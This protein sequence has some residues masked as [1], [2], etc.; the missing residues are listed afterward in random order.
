MSRWIE[1]LLYL[2][3][4]CLIVPMVSSAQPVIRLYD[5]LTELYPDSVFK[6][7][8]KEY[9]ID[10]AR[11]T[12]A[13]VHILMM[14][15]DPGTVARFRVVQG[16]KTVAEARWYRMID[17]P[18]E[19]NT[20]LD[21]RTEKFSGQINP[22][23]IRRAPFRIFEAL[24]PVRSPMAIDK[25]TIALRVEIPTSKEAA[26]KKRT[27]EIVIDID[28]HIEK[29][30]WIINVHNAVIPSLRHSTI[31][32]VNWHN[33]DNICGDH[34][35]KKWSE[36][37]WRMLSKY[38]KLMVRGRQNTF[39]LLWNDFFDFDS[40]GHMTVF[41]RQR[42]ER[43]VKVFMD[44]GLQK[45]QGCPFAFRENWSTDAMYV[46]PAQYKIPAASEDGL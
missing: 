37:F 25:P 39:W 20:G 8:M 29:L 3:G 11:G 30:H 9:T 18:V 5:E 38:A 24:D 28:R 7:G 17:V 33:L 45:I 42:L 15:M 12:I 26:I 22:F 10:A 13:G 23:V 19:E 44:G 35:V 21:S 46:I 16:N 36:P 1:K 6:E 31:S 32:Y 34:D 2:L 43:Y 40:T 27:F 14:G 4:L 41:H